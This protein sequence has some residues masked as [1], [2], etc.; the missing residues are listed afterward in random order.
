VILDRMMG[1]P[2]G[3]SG[4]GGEE[5]FVCWE[6]NLSHP[7]EISGSHTGEYKDDCLLRC[8]V[9]SGGKLPTFY[10]SSLPLSSR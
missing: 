6:L 7:G 1:G 3:Q 4:S 5:K 9:K 10:R 8:A 2:Q